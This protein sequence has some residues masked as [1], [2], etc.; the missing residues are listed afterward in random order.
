MTENTLTVRVESSDE[1]FDRALEAAAKVDA[2][3]LTDGHTGVSLQDETTLA[4]VLSEKNLDLIRAIAREEPQSLRELARLVDRDIKN[5]SKAINDL[6]Q[7]GLVEFKQDGQSK[8]P[9]VWYSKIHVEY[10]LGVGSS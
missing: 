9:V 5:V 2:G 4:R 3:E 8:R 6:A 10:D 1:F 7:L